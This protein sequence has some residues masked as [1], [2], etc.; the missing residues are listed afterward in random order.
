MKIEVL[1]VKKSSKFFSIIKKYKAQFLLCFFLCLISAFFI[2]NPAKYIA[3]TIDGIL[4]YG[5]KILPSLLP[6][7]FI[8]KLMSN[9]E[10]IFYVCSKFKWLTKFLFCT[11]AISFYIF[12]MSI[13]SGYP[14]GAKLTSEFYSLGL[15]TKKDA[16]KILSF[17]STSGPLFV[18]GSVGVGFFSSA[19]IGFILFSSHI[20]SSIINGVIFGHINLKQNNNKKLNDLNNFN[21][22][23]NQVAIKNTTRVTNISSIEST[24]N[25]KKFDKFESNNSEN[26]KEKNQ[27]DFNK[28]T[29]QKLS[30]DDIMYNSIRSV[31]M[32]GGFIIIFYVFI[33]IVL[34]YKLLY[35]LI[36]L[37]QVLGLSP[38]EAEGFCAG[39]FEIT[40]GI[41]ILSKSQNLRLSLTL[42]SFLISFSGISILMQSA[43]FLSKTDVNKKV[44]VIQKLL[45]GVISLLITY[46]FCL[47]L[48]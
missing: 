35:P 26:F 25:L 29:L 39:I 10:F 38:L 37:L 46:L 48:F 24:K 7:L 22:T 32:V 27:D 41:S 30:L 1:K 31:L 23:K 3:T 15:I 13:I 12:F 33:Q 9:F 8:T 44:F 14:I 18:I 19:K 47:F 40:K 16:Q 42:S 4:L 45:H 17:S 34:D 21:S 5:T 28:I 20:I 43:S 11:P 6:F 2:I 36:K